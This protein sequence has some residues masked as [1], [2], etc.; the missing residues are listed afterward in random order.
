MTDP[1]TLPPLALSPETMRALGYR[2]IDHLVDRLTG[3]DS[4]P[5]T[6]T[7]SRRAMEEKLREPIP[8]GGT[9]PD[10]VL[11][12]VL[13]D[14]FPHVISVDHPRFFAFVPGP[15]NFVGLLADTLAAGHNVFAG[16]WLA[17]AGAAEIEIVTID[18]LRTL[19]GFPPSTAGLFVSGG[20]VATLTALTAARH[21]ILGRHQDDAIVYA[22]DQTHNSLAKD[23]RVLGFAPG[24]LRTLPSDEGFRLSAA[25][26]GQAIADDRAAGRRPFCVVA[27][28]GTTSTGAVDPLPELAA[29][30][31]AEGLWLHVDGA[32]GAAAVLTESGRATLRGMELA[33]S[34][35]L[36]PHKW[37]FQP[38]EMGC[39]LVRDARVLRAAFATDAEAAY[40]ADTRQA[41]TTWTAGEVNFYEYGVQLTRA[42]RALK[43]WMSLQV[44]GLDAFRQ[45]VAQGIALAEVAERRLRAAPH[46]E[47]V[48]PAQLGVVTFRYV[49]PGASAAEVDACN[50][51]IV[52]PMLADGYA[53]VTSTALRGRPVLRLCPIH[54]AATE[55]EI[56]ETIARLERF[57]RAAAEMS[58]K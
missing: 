6:G 10:A 25:G 24:Q 8:E 48:T 49:P 44:F 30:C 38:Y 15:S 52:A 41:D 21:A 18:W 27:N 36:D 51:A 39:V 16:H 4:R 12:R 7:A 54:P 34:L 14:V 45:A 37:W 29:I 42:F 22:S 58:R 53:V 11:D 2:V 3:L 17:G 23:L 57:G 50:R 56:V 43:L 13:R 5:A 35:T 31:R 1:T 55:Q 26:L 20:S 28:A 33:D 9:A 47:V 19:C 40:L 32:Y 46:W